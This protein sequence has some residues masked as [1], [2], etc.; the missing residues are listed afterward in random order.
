MPFVYGACNVNCSCLQN[1]LFKHGGS[2][3]KEPFLFPTWQIADTEFSS[4]IFNQY[5]SKVKSIFADSLRAEQITFST[6]KISYFYLAFFMDNPALR[7]F[8]VVKTFIKIRGVIRK[9][10][11]KCY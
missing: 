8:E 10:A 6:G 2:T 5:L 9:F 3:S 1:D 11:E 7:L 4:H